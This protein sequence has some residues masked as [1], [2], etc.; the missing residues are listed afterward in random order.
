MSGELVWWRP[1]EDGS[2]EGPILGVGIGRMGQRLQDAAMQQASEGANPFSVRFS[3]ELVVNV[4][5]R[6]VG[7]WARLTELD[8]LAAHIEKEH[9]LDL[10]EVR[11]RLL[12]EDGWVMKRGILMAPLWMD[13]LFEV[14]VERLR[15]KPKFLWVAALR[16]LGAP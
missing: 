9:R 13:R 10:N 16:T 11:R 2:Q 8:Q 15:R 6:S 1:Y 3:D 14:T 5:P 7:A 4:A 12:R